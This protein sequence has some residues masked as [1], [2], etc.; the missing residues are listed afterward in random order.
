[1]HHFKGKIVFLSGIF[2]RIIRIVFAFKKICVYRNELW[3]NI[4]VDIILQK[5]HIFLLTPNI[6][7]LT[8]RLLP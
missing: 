4:F 8:Q 5:M 7:F 3:V 2:M 6:K 1:M